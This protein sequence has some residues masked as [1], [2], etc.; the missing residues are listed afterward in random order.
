MP[1]HHYLVSIVSLAVFVHDGAVTDEELLA[2]YETLYNDPEVDVSF[3]QL[4]DLR[5][6]DSSRRSAAA[7][8]QLVDI[9]RSKLSCL[10]TQP[11]IAVVA[12]G[13]LSFGLAR[14][15]EAF[16][17]TMST[18]IMVFRTVDEALTWLRIPDETFDEVKRLAGLSLSIYSDQP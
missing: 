17:Q 13:D 1:V 10:A 15:F 8:R 6:A 7:L 9:V 3:N 12:P 18:E 5:R 14:M 11:R 4:V 2:S 16:S